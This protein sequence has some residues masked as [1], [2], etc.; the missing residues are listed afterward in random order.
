LCA[1]YVVPAKRQQWATEPFERAGIRINYEYQLVPP[2]T[3]HY[4]YLVQP[5]GWP[6]AQ[7]L[8]GKDFFQT[9][10][11]LSFDNEP[12]TVDDLNPL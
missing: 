1:I 12:L 7:R 2:S 6:I 3:T 10:T 5:P 9:A 4:S 8:L 11:G